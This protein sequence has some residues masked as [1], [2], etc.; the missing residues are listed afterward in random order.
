MG[1]YECC[2]H[3]PLACKTLLCMLFGAAATLQ[4]PI[5]RAM[6]FSVFLVATMRS[7]RVPSARTMTAA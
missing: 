3:Q 2:A 6:G 1:P 5:R 4:T 7:S